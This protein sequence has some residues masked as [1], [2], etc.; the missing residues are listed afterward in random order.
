MGGPAE[1]PLWIRI[2]LGVVFIIAG[3]IVLGDATVAT[4]ISTIVIAAIQLGTLDCGGR[5]TSGHAAAAPPSSVMKSRR[6][7]TRSPRR[8]GQGASAARRDPAP[9]RS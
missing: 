9:S 1:V 6:L 8:R 4:T 5:A 3:V 7:L 2:L